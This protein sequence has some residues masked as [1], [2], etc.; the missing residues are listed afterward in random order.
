MNRR[1]FLSAMG[2]T[3]AGF[4]VPELW[5][6]KRTFFLPPPGG[7]AARPAAL[8]TLTFPAPTAAWGRCVA[9]ICGD[10]VFDL[11]TGTQ[12]VRQQKRQKRMTNSLFARM[13]TSLSQ[14]HLSA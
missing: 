14:T 10:L 3:A 9:V 11:D 2:L 8:E 6:P 12:W 5:T 7:W 4:A 13:A 1:G